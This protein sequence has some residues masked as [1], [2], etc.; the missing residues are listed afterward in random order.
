MGKTLYIHGSGDMRFAR[1]A[2]RAGQSGEVLFGAAAVGLSGSD[3]HNYKD[4]RSGA[5]RIKSPFVSGHELA[6][7]L[8]ESAQDLGRLRGALVAVDPNRPQDQVCPPDGR[9]LSARN[10]RG[11]LRQVDGASMATHRNRPG[12]DTRRLSRARK[13]H[14]DRSRP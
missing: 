4:G 13:T 11:G 5:A 14:L 3:P 1:F 2:H 7:Y 9:S 8:C 10:R 6:G 12:R